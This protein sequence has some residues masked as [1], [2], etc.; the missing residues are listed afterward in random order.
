MSSTPKEEPSTI[1]PSS[2]AEE[3]KG[4]E[5]EEEEVKVRSMEDPM[6]FLDLPDTKTHYLKATGSGRY[7]EIPNWLKKVASVYNISDNDTISYLWVSIIQNL[8]VLV[9][10]EAEKLTSIEKKIHNFMEN[11]KKEAQGEDEDEN[12]DEDSMENEKEKYKLRVLGTIIHQMQ[13]DLSRFMQVYEEL[14][15]A[16]SHDLAMCMDPEEHYCQHTVDGVLRITR[17]EGAVCSAYA[18]C[19]YFSE[20]SGKTNT[21]PIV[22]IPKGEDNTTAESLHKHLIGSIFSWMDIA[23]YVFYTSLGEQIEQV[24]EEIEKKTGETYYEK[25]YIEN[26]DNVLGVDVPN[27]G[28]DEEYEASDTQF[29]LVSF[30]FNRRDERNSH[31]YVREMQETTGVVRDNL[32]Y[33]FGGNVLTV[34]FSPMPAP[35]KWAELYTN[36]E[37]MSLA[38]KMLHM[39]FN[40]TD[41][42]KEKYGEKEEGEEDE[43][44]NEGMKKKRLE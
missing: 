6:S 17:W 12:T 7:V 14:S 41:D 27:V 20:T 1:A 11:E 25:Y 9:T 37:Y 24:N 34:H 19:Q 8:S 39:H 36:S 26:E 44:N 15:S 10:S 42:E 21:L 30:S 35:S 31:T 5:E 18:L 29:A 13:L 38:A 22:V 4:E 23:K 2:P 16:E 40:L 32:V 28:S 33:T 3:K 43:N